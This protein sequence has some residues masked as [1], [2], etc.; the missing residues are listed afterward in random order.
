MQV[1]C[2]LPLIRDALACL[3]VKVVISRLLNYS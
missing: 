2:T 1:L 3:Y